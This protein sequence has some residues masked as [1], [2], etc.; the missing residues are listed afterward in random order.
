MVMIQESMGEFIEAWGACA[1]EPIWMLITTLFSAQTFHSGSQWA[2]W[3]LGW[4][5][6]EGLSEKEMAWQPLATTRL[7]SATEALRSQ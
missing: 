2:S 5:F 3:M 1:P 7:I 4:P 6:S